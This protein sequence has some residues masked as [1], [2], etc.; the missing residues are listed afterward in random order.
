MGKRVVFRSG[1]GE[2]LQ[3]VRKVRGA[4]TYRS[5]TGTGPDHSFFFPLLAWCRMK[6]KATLP[7]LPMSQRARHS[8]SEMIS[9]LIWFGGVAQGLVLNIQ[10]CPS[11]CR[12][13]KKVKLA[14]NKGLGEMMVTA[15]NCTS[16][17]LTAEMKLLTL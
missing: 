1:K 17:I 7:L 3:G 13:G 8:I 2:W 16:L 9:F 11:E 4:R 10:C 12:G 5:G 15:R 6:Y 14:Q